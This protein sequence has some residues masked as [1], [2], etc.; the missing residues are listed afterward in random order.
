MRICRR[1]HI[2]PFDVRFNEGG[3]YLQRGGELVDQASPGEAQQSMSPMEEANVE[4]LSIK[5]HRD[6]WE[7]LMNGVR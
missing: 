6:R 4:D 1:Y 3:K 2:H 7:A 5:M